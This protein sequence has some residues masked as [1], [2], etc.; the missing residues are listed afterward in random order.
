MGKIEIPEILAEIG[1]HLDLKSLLAFLLVDKTTN[2]F[3][4]SHIN[5]N[6]NFW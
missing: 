2:R 4:V 1:F 5:I 3:I 6:Q